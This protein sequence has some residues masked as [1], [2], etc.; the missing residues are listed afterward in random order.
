MHNTEMTL[1]V[2]VKIVT[3]TVAKG[4]LTPAVSRPGCTVQR[5]KLELVKK[6]KT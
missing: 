2:F 1:S 5:P 6:I 3:V 4:S